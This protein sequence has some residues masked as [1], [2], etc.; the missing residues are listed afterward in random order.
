MHSKLAIVA[1]ATLL[2][3]SVW[4]GQFHHDET[5]VMLKIDGGDTEV[6]TIDDLAVG[7]TR[8]FTTESG[9]SVLVARDDSGLVVD[10]D[11]KLI[12]IDTPDFDSVNP[13]QH[14]V[15]VMEDVD[16]SIEDGQHIIIKRKQV[17]ADGDAVDIDQLLSDLDLDELGGEEEDVIVIKKKVEISEEI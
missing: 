1:A 5:K 14:R 15:M 10:V 4:A 17:H 9:K 16:E 6:L 7:E 11:G 8:E 13:G 2:C 12:E 3:G